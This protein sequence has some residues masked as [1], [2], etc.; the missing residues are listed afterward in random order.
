MNSEIPE[1]S[2]I[3]MKF[4]ASD[5]YYHS[6]LSWLH[7]HSEGFASPY[8]DRWVNNIYFD[9]HDLTA[10]DENLSGASSRTKVRYRW[11][12]DSVYPDS[13]AL[14]VK[15]RRNIYGWKSRFK[16]VKTPYVEGSSWRTIRGLLLDQLPPEG[17]RWLDANPVPVLINRY[18][19]KYFISGEGDV[20]ATIDSRQKVMEQRFKAYPNVIHPANIPE[21]IV[22]E[23]KFDRK[24]YDKASHMI[25]GI[26][27]RRGRHS[28]YITGVKALSGFF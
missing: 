27:I 5:V 14:E 1:T 3:E 22:V 18:F 7:L 21:I 2:R 6:V 13:G 24:H 16:V 20:R 28:K 19:R 17:K 11:Y 4:I 12:G 25:Q 9:T 15:Q 10:Y 8:A 23:F 26:P